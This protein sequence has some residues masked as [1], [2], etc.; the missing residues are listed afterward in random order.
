M[1][2]DVAGLRLEPD[3]DATAFASEVGRVLGQHAD[4]SALREAWDSEDGRIPKLWERLVEM[5]VTGLVVPES[6]GGDGLDLAAAMPLLMAAGRAA[7]PEPLTSTIAGSAVLASLTAA[8]SA[9]AGEWLPRIAS[10]QTTVGLGVGHGRIVLGGGWADVLL[11][12]D[13]DG[14]AVHLVEAADVD[15]TV[16]PAADRGTRLATVRWTPKSATVLAGVSPA[17][18]LDVAAGCLAA[19]LLGASYALLEMSTDYA[20]TREQ[21]GQVIGAFQAVKHQLADVYVV[22]AFARP[23]VAKAMWS[24]SSGVEGDSANADSRGRAASH[25]LYAAATAAGRAARAA[26]QV[27]AGIG[28]TYEHD[29]HMWLKRTWTL[30]TVLGPPAWHRERVARSVLDGVATGRAT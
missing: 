29:L 16:E 13:H 28:Y 21:F 9:C 26:L 1:S 4:R 15:L 24:L 20:K 22:I 25:G 18:A 2:G 6:A 10:G 12:T 14:D 3:A 30:S 17:M 7:L 8:G 27:H 23:V 5:G 11:L 19:E